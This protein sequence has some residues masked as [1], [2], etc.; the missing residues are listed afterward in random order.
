MR[1]AT[2]R[3]SATSRTSSQTT[4]NSSPPTRATVSPARRR[5]REALRG[6]AQELVA[7]GVAEAV[8]DDLEAIEVDQDHA[9]AVV[10]SH[11]S[12]QRTGDAVPQQRAVGELGEG[13]VQR[14]RASDS[15]ICLRSVTSAWRMV[16]DGARRCPP[17]PSSGRT[18]TA[19][20]V[21][22]VWLPPGRLVSS[23]AGSVADILIRDLPD[24]S[25][26]SEAPPTR[27]SRR[28]REGPGGRKA[29]TGVTRHCAGGSNGISRRRVARLG[30]LVKRCHLRAP[31]RSPARS[32]PSAGA[33]GPISGPGH[34]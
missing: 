34:P 19:R 4:T 7:G 25:T 27:W 13:V 8:V 18:R 1:S 2:A 5:P 3:T 12:I 17:P 30:P 28:P 21:R 6:V 14:G 16:R 11:R 23:V 15:S 24:S 22:T 10:G 29:A 9:G 31:R 26:F 33:A 32:R 20:P